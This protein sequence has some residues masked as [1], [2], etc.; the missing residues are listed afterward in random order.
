MQGGREAGNKFI[1]S[2]CH[3]AAS[4]PARERWREGGREGERGGGDKNFST[5]TQF[6][7]ERRGDTR[8]RKRRR[9]KAGKVSSITLYRINAGNARRRWRDGR[10]EARGA[11]RTHGHPPISARVMYPLLGVFSRYLLL[12]TLWKP[13]E[14]GYLLAKLSA[15]P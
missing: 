14:L 7:R 5:W 15:L 2:C 9:R 4:R 3:S 1:L 12:Q 11:P 13:T 6:L 8:R 10:E